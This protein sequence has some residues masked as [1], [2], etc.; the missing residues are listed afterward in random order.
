MTQHHSEAS[1]LEITETYNS[2][3]P[4]TR[5]LPVEVW[6]AK[7]HGDGASRYYFQAV[8]HGQGS[9]TELEP[10]V[11]PTALPVLGAEVRLIAGF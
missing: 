10:L 11:Q 2:S 3:W 5:S 6:T 7:R 1:Q 9:R 8:Y 4:C